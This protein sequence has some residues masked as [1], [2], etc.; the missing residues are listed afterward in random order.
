MTKHSVEGMW[1]LFAL[2]EGWSA[3]LRTNIGQFLCLLNYVMEPISERA[4]VA[5]RSRVLEGG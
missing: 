3:A 4:F 5:A 2:W 1:L